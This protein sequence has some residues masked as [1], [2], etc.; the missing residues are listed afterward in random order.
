[1]AELRNRLAE[2]VD[3]VEREHA[4]VVITK[5]GRP[6][7]VVVSAA[8]LESLEET[9]DIMETRAS[10]PTSRKRSWSSGLA[11]PSRSARTRRFASL[12][13]REGTGRSLI[14]TSISFKTAK[15][16]TVRMPELS[17]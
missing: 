5:H 13:D 3:M 10:S 12:M 2:V 14:R 17:S 9:L 6:A 8:D 15:K 11:L 7:A 16:L 4:R 1:M